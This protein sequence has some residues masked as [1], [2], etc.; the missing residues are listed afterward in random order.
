[1]Q[2]S[3]GGQLE[4]MSKNLGVGRVSVTNIYGKVTLKVK[5]VEG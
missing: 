4:A 1:L 5:Y 3:A 2:N